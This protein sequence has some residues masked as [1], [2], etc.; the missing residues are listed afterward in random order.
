MVIKVGAIS[1]LVFTDVPL[2]TPKSVR[3]RAIFLVIPTYACIP[4][5]K[6]LFHILRPSVSLVA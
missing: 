2:T 6:T 1:Y 5:Q 3:R 4:D